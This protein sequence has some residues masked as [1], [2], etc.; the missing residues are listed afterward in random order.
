[1]V[2][3]FFFD[4]EKR[5][6]AERIEKDLAYSGRLHVRTPSVRTEKVRSHDP[7]VPDSVGFVRAVPVFEAGRV[8]R[9]IL[10]LDRVLDLRSVVADEGKVNVRPRFPVTQRNFCLRP[11]ERRDFPELE[12]FRQLFG[13]NVFEVQFGAPVPFGL[14][15]VVRER[16]RSVHMAEMGL[17]SGGNRILVTELHAHRLVANGTFPS[18]FEIFLLQ[19]G[20]GFDGLDQIGNVPLYSVAVEREFVLC[21]MPFLAV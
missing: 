21:H 10:D 6:V 3:P 4:I 11:V 15:F 16:R 13:E 2:R 18:D 17:L 14:G 19:T 9:G 7:D 5:H 1:M 8:H 12:H 20:V